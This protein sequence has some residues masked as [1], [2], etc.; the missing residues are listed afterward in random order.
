MKK[1]KLNWFGPIN[2]L[3]GKGVPEEDN[4]ELITAL[5]KPGIYLWAYPKAHFGKTGIYV[6]KSK[7]LIKRHFQHLGYWLNGHY[8]LIDPETLDWVAMPKSSDPSF[9]A[10]VEK[11]WQEV[12]V[13]KTYFAKTD[14]EDT[15][16]FAER[17]FIEA[18][19]QL[20]A[21]K[22]GG[23]FYDQGVQQTKPSEEPLDFKNLGA[24]FVREVFGSEVKWSP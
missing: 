2:F 22:D 23:F 7:N 24:P 1:I 17:A 13:C 21:K 6:G 18:F 3:T 9:D 19:Q 10:Y 12:R 14:D 4:S 8:S 20:V 16:F 11:A 5:A 15:A